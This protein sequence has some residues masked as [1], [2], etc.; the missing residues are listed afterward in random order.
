MASV[1]TKAGS[2]AGGVVP[3]V[4]PNLILPGW[5]LIPAT[6]ALLLVVAPILALVLNIPWG[7]SWALLTHP[8][9]LQTLGLSLSTAVVA[10]I[11]CTVLGFPLA[12]ALHHHGR[13]H[14]QGMAVVQLLVYAPL[15]LS[16]VVSGLALTYLWGRKGLVGQYLDQWGLPIAFTTAAVV[17]TQVFVALPFFVSTVVTALRGI[18]SRFEELAATEGATRWEIMR[19]VIIP[20]SL[21]GIFTGMILGFARAL[22]EY[23]ATLTFAGNVAGVTRTIPLHIELGLSSNDMDR[24]LG[25]VIM[26]LAVY[27]L[28]IGAIAVVRMLA[29]RNR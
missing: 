23:G 2:T 10:T 8:D 27:V 22:G 17:L 19:R 9:A 5:M 6:V 18:P 28:I 25:A 3:R 29:Q 14:P 11:L 16:P 26:L 13:N 21:P 7:R 1:Q 24:A 4:V 20:L 15:V 12:L